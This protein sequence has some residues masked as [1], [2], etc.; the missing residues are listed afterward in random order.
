MIPGLPALPAGVTVFVDAVLLTADTISLAPSNA[1]QWGLFN[2]D[3]D[4]VVI[5]DNLIAFE[6]K[7]DFSISNY[8]VEQGQFSSFNKVQRPFEVRLRFSTGGSQP[9]REALLN[10]IQ[11]IV[12]DTNLYTAVTPEAVYQ[13]LNLTH[14]EYRRTS[15]NGVG[16][17][18]VDVWC[19][20]VRST[21]QLQNSNTA[22]TSSGAASLTPNQRVSSDFAALGSPQSPTDAS[23]VNGGNVQPQTPTAAQTTAFNNAMPLP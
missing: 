19:E 22:T 5:A 4:P 14:Q 9:D 23:P 16:L 6:Y 17:I 8:P 10:S 18:S 1:P 12:G 2:S 11:A 13:S 20:Q 21:A 3:G 15:A 7:Q